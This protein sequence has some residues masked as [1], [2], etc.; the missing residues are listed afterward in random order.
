MAIRDRATMEL[1]RGLAEQHVVEGD[2]GL[3]SVI[4]RRVSFGNARDGAAVVQARAAALDQGSHNP[5]RHT[6]DTWSSEWGEPATQAAQRLRK[7]EAMLQEASLNELRHRAR[8]RIAIALESARLRFT[9]GDDQELVQLVRADGFTTP[10]TQGALRELRLLQSHGRPHEQRWARVLV[11]KLGRALGAI[12][13]GRTRLPKDQE[14]KN[15]WRER[16]RISDATARYV[17]RHEKLMRTNRYD[18]EQAIRMVEEDTP[19]KLP[20]HV[21]EPALRDFKAQ[22]RSGQ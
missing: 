22:I 12:G 13:S 5:S 19:S 9:E 1:L 4:D 20:P 2:R 16:R 14:K 17:K 11:A 8:L 18:A 21:R 15:L 6:T 10:W 3:R 7:Y